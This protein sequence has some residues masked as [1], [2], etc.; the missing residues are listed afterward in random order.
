[1]I[2]WR[3]IA[4]ADTWEL[5]ARD[6]L[7]EL[8]FVIEVGP[9][10]GP[11]AGR[12]LLVSEQLKGT[13]HTNKFAWLVSCKHFAGSRK[14]VG[15]EDELNITDRLEHHSADGFLGFYSTLPSAAL[16]ARLKEYKDQ[17]RIKAY[18]I[19]DAKKIEGYFASAGFSKL[20][21]K[22]FPESYGRLRPIQQ[23]LGEIVQLRCDECDVDILARSVR[24]GPHANLVW[25]I[26]IGKDTTEYEEVFVVCK[27]KCDHDLQ[28]RL[29]A[30]GYTT[31]WEEMA[32]LFNP[33]LFLKNMLTYMNMLHE[34]QRRFSDK[35]HKRM[36]QIYI[37]LAQ[38]TL[39]EVT[40]EDMER[41]KE[42][43]ILD[44]LGI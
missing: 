18:E 33:I 8:G 43:R 30:Q 4:D 37:A 17:G 13:L 27:G 39:R 29:R 40:K 20:A 41:F 42:L 9:G 5:F 25:S 19:F 31:G 32:D 7:A 34:N 24:E 38:R 23:L 44:N 36:K 28:E 16:V 2:D 21:L 11:D 22:Y 10:R 14:S 6:F 12:D 26:P 15:T 3:E 35:A 1:M